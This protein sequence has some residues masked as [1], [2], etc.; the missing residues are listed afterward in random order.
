[1]NKDTVI[2]KNREFR[3]TYLKGKSE[4]SPNLVTYI[5]KNRYKKNRMGITTGKKIG[6]AVKRNRARRVI[7]CAYFELQQKLKPGFDI[8]FVGRV[9][10]TVSK[11]QVVKNEMERQFCKLGI[12]K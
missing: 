9:K 12:L 5:I 6:N 11:M 10:T 8:V 3:R 1:M 2:R 4:V 7:K